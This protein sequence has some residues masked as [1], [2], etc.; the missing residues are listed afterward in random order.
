MRTMKQ[1][2]FEINTIFERTRMPKAKPAKP[3]KPAGA[4]AGSATEELPLISEFD[5]PTMN[6][7][8]RLMQEVVEYQIQEAAIKAALESTKAEII[9]I[10]KENDVPGMRW[11]SLEARC[12]FGKTRRTLSARRLAENGV[13]ADVIAASYEESKA[14]DEVRVKDLSL[15]R[16][17]AVQTNGAKGKGRK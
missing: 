2:R 4:R 13:D 15:D 11:G 7:A 6:Q 16:E 12:S 14:W 10:A 8:R 1:Y 5:R 3:T 17:E 9:A